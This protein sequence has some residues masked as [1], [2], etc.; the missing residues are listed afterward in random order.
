MM[1]LVIGVVGPVP[2]RKGTVPLRFPPIMSGVART[3]AVC[4]NLNLQSETVLW[5]ASHEGRPGVANHTLTHSA[6]E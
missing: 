4:G 3:V 2:W 5:F 6:G 1:N